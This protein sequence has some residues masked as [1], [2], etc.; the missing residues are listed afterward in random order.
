MSKY[1]K[2]FLIYFLIFAGVIIALYFTN[3]GESASSG[4]EY[5][6]SSFLSD[7]ANT[8][9]NIKK[10]VLTNNPDIENTGQAEVTHTV[11]NVE[12]VD[13]FV[14]PDITTFSSIAEYLTMNNGIPY[15][16]HNGV[17]KI[18]FSTILLPVILFIAIILLVIFMF[19]RASGGGEGQN[20]MNFGKSRAK[21]V[22]DDSG[23]TT[24]DSVAGLDE[25]K[26]ELE[27]VVDFLSNPESFLK[28]GAR[29]PKG[30]LLVGPP[31]TGKTLLA[32]AVAGEAGVPF[33]SI[34]GSDFV[35]MFVGVGASRVRDLFQ[36]AKKNKP[37]LIFIDEIDAVGRKRG[38]GLG[39]SHD[40]REQTL[41]QLL[42]EMDGFATDEGII[43]LAATNRV[44]I[45]DPAILRPGRFDRK[46]T[47]NPP[48]IKGRLEM[49][50]LH[51][52][53]KKLSDDVDFKLIAQQTVGFTGADIENLLNE[54]AILA[55]RKDLESFDMEC[56]R[57]AYIKVG[58]GMEKKNRL[59]PDKEK[60]MTA[61][62]EVGHAIL[63]EMLTELDE[64][65]IVSI[66]P[67]GSA[68]G[69]TMYAPSTD[70]SYASKKSMEQDIVSLLGGRVAEEL[71]CGDITTGASSD[72][73]RAT[74]IARAMVTR[75]GMSSLGPIQFSE[76]EHD[77]FLGRDISS[78]RS[79]SQEMSAKI[80]IEVSKIIADAY[81]VA[82]GV[83]LKHTNIIEKAVELLLEKDKIIGVE[84]RALFPVGVIPKKE[85]VIDYTAQLDE[86]APIAKKKATDAMERQ[87]K[88]KNERAKRQKEKEKEEMERKKAFLEELRREADV[89]STNQKD[90]S[91]LDKSDYSENAENAEKV[92]NSKKEE[93]D[94]ED[95]K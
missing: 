90:F 10:I 6:Y 86:Y 44:D 72:I 85:N 82:K 5:I 60:R 52:N 51:S 94:E 9:E 54:A 88:I 15:E 39:G 12:Y 2:S 71:F 95:T 32:K 91:K 1:L 8:P 28:I 20:S 77:V 63:H 17:A 46:V 61:Y 70:M 40:E 3:L 75:Y 66:I 4:D 65:Q 87:T 23:N 37:A 74:K 73:S 25:E 24:F 57:E 31:G 47:I 76:D 68:G 79:I 29:L 18:D 83:M 43:V 49:L 45:L 67:T 7:V 41:N 42:V 30:F 19:Q 21:M 36:Q 80:D 33:F 92:S 53:N 93:K 27:E 50:Y 59:I 69:Y 26:K 62:H 81:E 48:D 56:V 22:I 64:V 11:N 16:T 84:F 14:V 58:V 55:V 78:S 38:A 34:S 35:E 13:S 89:K